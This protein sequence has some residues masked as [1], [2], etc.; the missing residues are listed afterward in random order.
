LIQNYNHEPKREEFDHEPHE[1][2]RTE[3]AMRFTTNMR[4]VEKEGLSGF[5]SKTRGGLHDKITDKNPLNLSSR[6]TLLLVF[7]AASRSVRA[8]SCWFVV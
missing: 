7:Y 3:K 6:L 2:A 4:L 1:P 5:C 8:C